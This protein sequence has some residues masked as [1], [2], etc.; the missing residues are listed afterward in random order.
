MTT[1]LQKRVLITD[2]VAGGVNL[3]TWGRVWG[4]V[5]GTTWGGGA[6]AIVGAHPTVDVTKRVEG[7]ITEISTKRVTGE[8]TEVS[9]KRILKVDPPEFV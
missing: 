5:W 1:Q 9:T 7:V 3:S 2:G 4:D 6:S 8:I